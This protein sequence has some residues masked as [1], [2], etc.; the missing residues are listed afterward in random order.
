MST[1]SDYVTVFDLAQIGYRTWKFSAYGLIG[2][3]IGA[4]LVFFPKLADILPWAFRGRTRRIF[5]WVFFLFAVVWTAVAFA[6]TLSQYLSLKHAYDDGRASVVEGEV[7]NFRPMPYSGHADESFEVN[8]VHFRYSDYNV[9][10]GFNNT[11]SHGGPVRDGLPVR[12]TYLGNAILRLEIRAD[13]VPPPGDTMQYAARQK[14]DMDERIRSNPAAAS[15][16][17]GFAFAFALVALAWNIDWR[18]YMRYW[19]RSGPPYG[20][21]WEWGLRGFF[22]LCLLGS[23]WQVAEFVLRG[24]L[25]MDEYLHAALYALLAVGFFVVYDLI[26]RWRLR[27]AT[28]PRQE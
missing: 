15:V 1:P 2:V 20:R 19:K 17:L 16:S 8:G 24:T 27:H 5:I 14:A 23:L 9:T 11:A 26:V 28:R 13:S 21:Y 4:V 22:L 25:T 12:I 18:H 6:G 7:H 10:A 3:A